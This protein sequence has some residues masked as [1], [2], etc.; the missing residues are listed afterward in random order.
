MCFGN[1][2]GFEFSD[3]LEFKDLFTRKMATLILAVPDDSN[4]LSTKFLW[5][6]AGSLVLQTTSGAFIVPWSIGS[7]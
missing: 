3:K 2:L 4:A 1:N 7:G 6:A 5:Q